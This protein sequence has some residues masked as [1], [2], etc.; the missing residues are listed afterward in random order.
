M[1]IKDNTKITFHSAKRH[2]FSKISVAYIKQVSSNLH[3]KVSATKLEMIT[4][5]CYPL[6]IKY[7]GDKAK[8]CFLILIPNFKIKKKE[9]IKVCKAKG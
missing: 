5:T 6:I 1:K 8:F 4:L 2:Y 3:S 7:T 9:M